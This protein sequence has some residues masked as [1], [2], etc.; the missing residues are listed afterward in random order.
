MLKEIT[1]LILTFNESPNIRRTLERLTWAT[2]IVLVD[3]FSTDDTLEIARS[4]PS[5]R[6]LQRNFD[7]FALQCNFGLKQI[8]TPWVLSLD[9]DYILSE[10]FQ[11]EL[12]TLIP[13]PTISGYRARFVYCMYGRSLRASLYPPRAVLYR[14]DR[15]QYEDEGHGH[16]V[17]IDGEVA[18]LKSSIYHDDR[19]PLER[20]LSEQNRYMA[21]EVESLLG[22]PYRALKFQDRLRRWCVPAPFLVF[23]Y[24]LFWKGLILDGWPGWTYTLQ[25]T[26]A[27][28][29]LA[30]YLLQ[31][32]FTRP[33]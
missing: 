20:W 31:A 23:F 19:K 16:R 24:T 9:A 17:R 27:E 5:V 12:A 21:R 4:F 1:P 25:R 30:M 13:S 10:P 33:K 26:Y 15:A 29:L 14:R 18:S 3:S 28:I 6:I 11:A 8:K 7:T 22:T 32:R 2:E